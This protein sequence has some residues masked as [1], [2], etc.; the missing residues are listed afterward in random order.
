MVSDFH[1][2]LIIAGSVGGTCAL[3]TSILVLVILNCRH[4]RKLQKRGAER[5][6]RQ[7]LSAQWPDSLR[8]APRRPM[9]LTDVSLPLPADDNT[10]VRNAPW[11]VERFWMAQDSVND[12]GC[13]DLE[14]NRTD[15]EFFIHRPLPPRPRCSDTPD[16]RG[17]G[18][19]YSGYGGG[20]G[21]SPAINDRR[22]TSNADSAC[23]AS[24]DLPSPKPF[25]VQNDVLSGRPPRREEDSPEALA[26]GVATDESVWRMRKT[27]G[28]GA[29][30]EGNIRNHPAER[31]FGETYAGFQMVR[32]AQKE[33]QRRSRVRSVGGG[34]RGS[35]AS[36]SDTDDSE[37]IW[38]RRTHVNE[39]NGRLNPDLVRQNYS[40]RSDAA[41]TSASAKALLNNSSV[42]NKSNQ[43]SNDLLYPLTSPPSGKITAS[44]DAICHQRYS[45]PGHLTKNLRGGNKSGH[46]NGAVRQDV[47]N[48]NVK[49]KPTVV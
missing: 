35:A 19:G 12:S 24:F 22:S 17:R 34:R 38:I 45:V 7:R 5:L 46:S 44:E 16:P 39:I 40:S 10:Y 29:G 14:S 47:Y 9:T 2:K 31:D 11:D 25:Y 49:D 33:D 42:N 30:S 3:F 23:F 32:L 20:G 43:I 8:L 27:C 48:W 28:G 6:N 18:G 21:F 1:W 26:G 15:S 37:P 4:K 41:R 36:S 13:V